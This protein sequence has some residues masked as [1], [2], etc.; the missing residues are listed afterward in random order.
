[1]L[2]LR[3]VLLVPREPL[4]WGLVGVVAAAIVGVVVAIRRCPSADTVRAMLDGHWQCGGLLMAAGDADTGNWP[5]KMPASARPSVRWHGGRPCG[6]LLCCTCFLL[7][8]FLIPAAVL[9]RIRR[10]IDWWSALK[11]KSWLKKSNC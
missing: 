2:V 6:I 7:A 11:S 10:H 4:L 8:S 1:M 9:E 3:G 5:I